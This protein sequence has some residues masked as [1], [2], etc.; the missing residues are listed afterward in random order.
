VLAANDKSRVKSCGT[1]GIMF[2]A[3]SI[4]RS[5]TLSKNKK[6]CSCSKI[7]M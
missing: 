4:W 2:H 5:R 7:W 6:I 1:L 3:H